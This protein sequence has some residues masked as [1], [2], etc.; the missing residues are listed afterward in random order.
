MQNDN[1]VPEEHTVLFSRFVAFS[2]PHEG[3]SQGPCMCMYVYMGYPY[4]PLVDFSCF[5]FFSI[6]GD[7]IEAL[8]Y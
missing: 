5:R 2:G 1:K 7:V 4:P 3:L 6:W 8:E